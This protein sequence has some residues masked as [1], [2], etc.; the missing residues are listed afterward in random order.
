M[1]P[2]SK[3]GINKPYPLP[4]FSIGQKVIW[5]ERNRDKPFYRK[6]FLYHLIKK[7]Q[8][9]CRGKLSPNGKDI[10]RGCMKVFDEAQGTEVE[11]AGIKA[12]HGH[13]IDIHN[14]NQCYV[15]G[16][17]GASSPT[18]YEYQ[19]CIRWDEVQKDS[20]QVEQYGKFNTLAM[21]TGCGVGGNNS[22]KVF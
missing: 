22:F 10:V 20:N 21:I 15:A 16:V 2:A 17:D 3:L 7:W 5:N 19:I 12:R 8:K 14:F 1:T 18:D 9:V 11:I 13:N 6:K 4:H